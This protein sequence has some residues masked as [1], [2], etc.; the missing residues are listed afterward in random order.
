M[1]INEACYQDL[2]ARF[3][4]WASQNDDVRAVVQV[5]SRTRADHTADEWSD[6]DLLIFSRAPDRYMRETHWLARVGR[7]W[8]S[9][10]GRT[11]GGDLERLALFEGGYAVDF[12]WAPA[13]VLARAA[14]EQMTPDVIKRGCRL[15]LDKDGLAAPLIPDRLE[16][17][18]P[19]RP[20][21]VEFQAT[22]DAFWYVAVYMA[23]QLCRG[24][25]W[26]EKAIDAQ[27]KSTLL[28]ML[29]WH[30]LAR[31]GK[32]TWHRGRFMRDWAD[33]RALAQIPDT[34]GAFDLPS[35]RQALSAA[36]RLFDW[37]A[38]ET[39]ASLGYDYRRALYAEV[40]GYIERLECSG[41]PE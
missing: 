32:D 15:L 28:T 34:F 10:S 8:L 19:P 41:S 31:S 27:L 33:P 6:V 12:V 25:I 39:A 37:L 1:T 21:Q 22:C 16:K 36:M 7:L 14:S 40:E 11:V 20:T 13:E 17:P 2:V 29:E 38:Q 24:D 30:A 5:G 9:I 23:K 35:S 18:L 26:L 3:L 4:A